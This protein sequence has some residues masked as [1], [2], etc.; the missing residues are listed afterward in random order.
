MIPP[1][2]PV[3]LSLADRDKEEALPMIRALARA[4]H[5]LLATEGTARMIEALGLQVGRSPSASPRATPTC[6]TP[7]SRAG[8]AP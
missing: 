8:W 1:Q 3:L 4:G 2:A 6:W 7:S 5:P